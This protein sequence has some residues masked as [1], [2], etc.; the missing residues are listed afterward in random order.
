MVLPRSP[1]ILFALGIQNTVFGFEL[2]YTVRRGVRSRTT[3]GT[4]QTH[5]G[6]LLYVLHR[7]V[8]ERSMSTCY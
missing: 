6:R 2:G 4:T 3:S 8:G 5:L 1:T 7:I